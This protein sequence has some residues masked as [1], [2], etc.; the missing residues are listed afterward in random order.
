MPDY[1][2]MSSF[3]QDTSVVF[4]SEFHEDLTIK[5]KEE[6]CYNSLDLKATLVRYITIHIPALLH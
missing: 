2:I 6:Y 1:L 4:M 5:Y 3:W